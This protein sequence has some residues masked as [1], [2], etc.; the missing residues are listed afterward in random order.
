MNNKEYVGDMTEK[1]REEFHWQEYLHDK[2][3]RE[4]CS[5]TKE[6]S[7]DGLWLL[8]VFLIM[9]WICS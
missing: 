2:G 8:F 7:V 9:W 6:R 3:D 5:C 4:S 1:E